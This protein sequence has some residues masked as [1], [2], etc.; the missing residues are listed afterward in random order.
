[1]RTKIKILLIISILL[2]VFSVNVTFAW[3]IIWFSDRIDPSDPWS[4]SWFSNDDS[5]LSD[6]SIDISETN[7]DISDTINNV[8]LNILWKV[9]YIFSWVLLIFL[10][11]S[12]AQ[13]VMSLWTNE[14]ELS[15]SKKSIWYAMIWLVFINMPWTLY[16]AFKWS[17]RNVS[18]WIWDSW[19]GDIYNSSSNLFINVGIFQ[20]TLNDYIIKFVEVMMSSVAILIIIIAWIKIITAR[21]REEQVTEAKNKILWSAVWLIFIWLIEAWQSFAYSWNISDWTDIFKTIANLAL[22]MAWP[23]AIFFLT[24]AWY[25]YITS[26]WDEEKVK[27]WKTII[28]NTVLATAILLCSF[29]FLNDLITIK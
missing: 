15:N 29:I 21:W 17:N 16:N 14:D 19:T 18:W 8:W 6:T 1:M 27:K 12:W 9:K 4:I 25:Y 5:V 22:F 10:I 3:S 2:S 28:I 11:Y 24:L 26:N 20:T 23:I 7:S 13:M